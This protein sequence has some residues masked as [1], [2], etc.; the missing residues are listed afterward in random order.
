MSFERLLLKQTGS[1]LNGWGYLS[2]LL[3]L[4]LSPL[5]LLVS[6]LILHV[7]F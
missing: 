7:L 4:A 2:L 1:G 5:V 3:L 6:L